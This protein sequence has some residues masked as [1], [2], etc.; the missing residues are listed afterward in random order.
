MMVSSISMC[1]ITAEMSGPSRSHTRGVDST[2]KFRGPK[3]AL[4][5]AVPDTGNLGVSALWAAT[6]SGLLSRIPETEFSVFDHGHGRRTSEFAVRSRRVTYA[7][8]GAINTRRVYSRD[9]FWQIRTAAKL[10][11]LLNPAAQA[12][13]GA[14][15]LLDVSAGDSFTDLHGRY[16]MDAILAP[17]SLAIGHGI[18]L[19]L[20]P[21]TYGPFLSTRA[22]RLAQRIVRR[23]RAAWARDHDSFLKLQE[24]AGPGFE[25]GR[26]RLGVDMAF[27]LEPQRPAEPL[28]ERF[29]EWLSDRRVPIV[30]FN[31]SGLIYKAGSPSSIPAVSSESVRRPED[32]V[33][34]YGLR[35]DYRRA[36]ARILR[37]LLQED[38]CRIVL[39][40]HVLAPSGSYESDQDACADVVQQLGALAGD[41]VLVLPDAYDQSEVKWIIS[42]CEWFCGTRMHS[43]IA[44]L[45]SGV[46]AA[47]IAYSLKTQGVF[48]TCSQGEH[49][50]DLRTLSTEDLVERVL[51]SWQ[52]RDA[53]RAAL[54]AELPLVLHRA[55]QQMDEIAAVCL[56]TRN[57][58]VPA[59]VA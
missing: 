35:G 53:A 3:I 1:A 33:S 20:L 41:R 37:Q 43:S 25:P 45:S 17:K 36:L 55:E 49:V 13:L 29:E 23:C 30:G 52:Q 28:P 48:Q 2:A 16:R 50:H 42:Q 40:P 39:V 26:H 51:W 32:A 54:N 21:Q 5:G 31:V 12:I 8:Y 38:D 44:A 47:G 59:S 11:G 24:L 58:R 22:Q 56:E 15:V 57:G 14:D 4:F 46:P 6:M 10:G 34:R 18:P 27:C 9:S 7:R 19:V